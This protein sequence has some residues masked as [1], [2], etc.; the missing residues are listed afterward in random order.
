M[1]TIYKASVAADQTQKRACSTRGKVILC[2]QGADHFATWCKTGKATVVDM[3]QLKQKCQLKH[4]RP[5]FKARITCANDIKVG[6]HL[7]QGYPSHWFHFLVTE[8][9]P[10]D[11][12]KVKCIYCLRTKVTE[13]YLT[14]DVQTKQIYRIEYMESFAPDEAIRRARTEIGCR[15]WDPHARMSFVGWAKIGSNEGIEVGFLLNHT[16]PLSKNQIQSFAQLN[17]GDAIVKKEKYT[18]SHYYVV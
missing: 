13:C 16:S 9:D 15:Q 18:Y 10:N 1:S 2:Q 17:P 14:L 11:C 4:I 6:D 5:L 12:A 7:I 8:V 3:V